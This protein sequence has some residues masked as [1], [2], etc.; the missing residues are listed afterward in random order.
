M[1]KRHEKFN[2]EY[3]QMMASEH[4]KRYSTSVAMSEMQIEPH[5]RY[6]YIIIRITKNKKY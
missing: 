2:K 1:N 4:M 3:V 5:M 6:Q